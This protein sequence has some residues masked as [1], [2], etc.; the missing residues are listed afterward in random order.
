MVSNITSVNGKNG[1]KYSDIMALTPSSNMMLSDNVSI[2][3]K[4]FGN[5][6]DENISEEESSELLY[7]KLAEIED[8]QGII[9]GSWN[10][11][12]EL[13]NVGTSEEKCEKIIEQYEQ[14]DISFE[15]AEAAINNYDLKSESSLNLF[16]N[17]L[18]G[19][20]ALAAAASVAATG[21]MTAPIVA[22]ILAGA[23]TKTVFKGFDR[24][25]ND[26]KGDTIE[27]KQLAKDALSGALTGGIAVA[28][29]GTGANTYKK[30]LQLGSKTFKGTSA[31]A[32]KSAKTGIITG[33]YRVLQTIR[34][35][36]PLMTI[37][38]LKQKNVPQILLRE[39]PLA[40]RWEFLWA[41]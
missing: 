26:I 6:S 31:C 2:F 40:E 35:I 20:A 19:C 8:E 7:S 15:A 17:I 4:A 41:A 21:G 10:N 37:K 16:A 25:T 28:T 39:L 29:A 34:W 9:S 11:F 1:L 22:G 30:G 38:N 14:G 12:K 13:V 32:L 27:A 3:E 18:T 23:G 5:N 33:S 36:V 24:A